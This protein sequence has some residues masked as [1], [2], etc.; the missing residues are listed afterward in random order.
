MIGNDG[1]NRRE[2]WKNFEIISLKAANSLF[3]GYKNG[4]LVS[5]IQVSVF[6]IWYLEQ[7]N[8]FL[9]NRYENYA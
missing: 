5:Q 6:S 4:S 7:L 9:I 8:G 3:L 1:P 2:V